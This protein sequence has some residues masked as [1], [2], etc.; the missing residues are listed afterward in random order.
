MSLQYMDLPTLPNAAQVLQGD[1]SLADKQGKCVIARRS[2]VQ[3]GR[4]GHI[5]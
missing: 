5:H 3:L 4:K 2:G 1:M